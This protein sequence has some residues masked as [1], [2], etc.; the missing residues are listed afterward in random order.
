MSARY[1]GVSIS[2]LRIGGSWPVGRAGR[3]L[4]SGTE[5]GYH[6]AESQGSASGLHDDAIGPDDGGS[7]AAAAQ[8]TCQFAIGGGGDGD[9]AALT[10]PLPPGWAERFG[11]DQREAIPEHGV[12]P[13][14]VR[15]NRI[16][17]QRSR[18]LP[19]TPCLN[20]QR[21]AVQGRG[22]A[23]DDS[24][25]HT[26]DQMQARN[27]RGPNEV[28]DP[29]AG[30]HCPPHHWPGHGRRAARR[31]EPGVEDRRRAQW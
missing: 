29:T 13:A 7:C 8:P 1:T 12:E 15:Q 27:D 26:G 14:A 19:R 21:A 4:G 16:R 5:W 31:G 23:V 20:D 25:A 9:G 17:A 10:K 2:G 11:A 3:R 24:G 18:E 28:A 22:L 30:R 6:I